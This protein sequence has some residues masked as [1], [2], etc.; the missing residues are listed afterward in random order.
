[1][2][3]STYFLQECPTCGRGLEIRVEYFGRTMV[4]QHCSGTFVAAQQAAEPAERHA[5]PLLPAPR[6]AHSQAK[7][8]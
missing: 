8:G 7:A 6:M 2:V 1:M 5:E 3:R 4:C